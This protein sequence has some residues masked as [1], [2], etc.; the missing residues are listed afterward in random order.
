[1]K[2]TRQKKSRFISSVFPSR[3]LSYNQKNTVCN[4]ISDYLKIFEK[5]SI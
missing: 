1:M 2:N 4:F 3:K 5:K